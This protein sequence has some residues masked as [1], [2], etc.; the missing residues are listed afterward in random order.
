MNTN[1]LHMKDNAL[2]IYQSL[3]K[4]EFKKKNIGAKDTW[5]SFMNGY[6]KVIQNFQIK[7]YQIISYGI[8]KE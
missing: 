3:L 8:L 2:I 5:V 6:V 7:Y 1:I 4:F